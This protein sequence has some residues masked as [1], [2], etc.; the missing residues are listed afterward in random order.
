MTGKDS[1]V[2]K[3][4]PGI[5][6]ANSGAAHP[7]SAVK[8]Q[9]K[10]PAAGNSAKNSTDGQRRQHTSSIIAPGTA[11]QPVRSTAPISGGTS[12]VKPGPS[13]GEFGSFSLIQDING[14]RVFKDPKDWAPD[15][16]WPA[17]EE[18][19]KG[20]VIHSNETFKEMKDCIIRA[21]AILTLERRHDLEDYSRKLIT[22][23]NNARLPHLY[24]CADLK[25][26]PAYVSGFL[27]RLRWVFP[28]IFISGLKDNDGTTQSASYW[29]N[30]VADYIP[31]EASR[32]MIHAKVNLH[33]RVP[34]ARTVAN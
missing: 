26:V 18:W 29:G 8:G 1:S 15:E 27:A 24:P 31:K 22:Y 19:T 32:I 23:R 12:D 9:A 17:L 21:M 3:Q 28:D 5:V 6:A 34:A 33:Q 30:S 20:I 11:P 4:T 13:P 14:L 7:K 16:D 25:Y 10:T 2:P